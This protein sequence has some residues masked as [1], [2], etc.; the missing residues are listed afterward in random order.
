MHHYRW[1]P[2]SDFWLFLSPPTLYP[3]WK[4][5]TPIQYSPY[6]ISCSD[7]WAYS[8]MLLPWYVKPCICWAINSCSSAPPSWLESLKLDKFCCSR[9]LLIRHDMTAYTASVF[10]A[11]LTFFHSTGILRHISLNDLLASCV[12]YAFRSLWMLCHGHWLTQRVGRI[13]VSVVFAGNAGLRVQKK[14]R[15]SG[16]NLTRSFTS[17]V[18]FCLYSC[19]GICWI[20]FRAGANEAVVVVAQTDMFGSA[21]CECIVYGQSNMYVTL[22]HVPQFGCLFFRFH[23]ALNINLYGNCACMLVCAF[24]EVMFHIIEEMHHAFLPWQNVAFTRNQNRNAWTHWRS[25][26]LLWNIRTS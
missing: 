4:T 26:T 21:P 6:S 1:L 12:N 8:W 9:W 13:V 16:Q 3:S 2:S 20:S 10:Y 17:S 15:A 19:S 11:V 7:Y 25:M 14:L 5:E 22:C 23:G 18:S 24:H